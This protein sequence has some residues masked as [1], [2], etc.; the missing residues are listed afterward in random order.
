ML[1]FICLLI[2]GILCLVAELFVP[3]GVIGAAGVL[4]LAAAV[5]VG[6]T[7]FET[8]VAHAILLGVTLVGLGGFAAW[9]RYFPHSRIARP[10]VQ[11][12]TVG[13]IGREYRR[14]LNAQGVAESDLRPSGRAR[15]GDELVDVIADGAFI[16]AGTAIEVVEAQGNRLKVRAV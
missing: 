12:A 8:S 6:Y 1:T 3:G 11:D 9:I 2:L 5:V 14:F 4:C 15:F 13:T 7:T 16:T 10:L